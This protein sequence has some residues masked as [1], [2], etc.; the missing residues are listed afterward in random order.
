M[1]PSELGRCQMISVHSSSTNSVILIVFHQVHV[2]AC[3]FSFMVHSKKKHSISKTIDHAL[4]TRGE[5]AVLVIQVCVCNTFANIIRRKFCCWEFIFNKPI[6]SDIWPNPLIP[7]QMS[8]HALCTLPCVSNKPKSCLCKYP[9]ESLPFNKTVRHDA[10]IITELPTILPQRFYWFK[11]NINTG[12]LIYTIYL[13]QK[14]LG[15]L[16][17]TRKQ[18]CVVELEA[19]C[20][21]M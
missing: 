16:S 6:C 21:H 13:Q 4:G 8:V 1:D 10:L 5:C 12:R 17:R 19:L 3:V 9:V 15:H 11:Q 7:K 14:S 2:Y 18:I 20:F